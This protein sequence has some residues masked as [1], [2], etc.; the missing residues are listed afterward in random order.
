MS[1]DD[2]GPVKPASLCSTHRWLL[3]TQAGFRPKDPW[4]ALEIASQVALFQACTTDDKIWAKLGGDLHRLPEIGCMACAKPDAF[5]EIVAAARRRDA[6]GAI[7]AIKALGDAWIAAA[8][9][10]PA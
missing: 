8:R 7:G 6:H 2:K 10:D 1:S 4:M 3:V 5:G 9:K